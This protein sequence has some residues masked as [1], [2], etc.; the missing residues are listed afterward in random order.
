MVL[1]TRKNELKKKE[2]CMRLRKIGVC[3]VMKDK[4]WKMGFNTW[5]MNVL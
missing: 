1:L 3:E 4:E 5:M 2:R